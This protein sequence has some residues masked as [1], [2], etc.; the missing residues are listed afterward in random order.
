MLC[1]M[2]GRKVFLDRDSVGGTRKGGQMASNAPY[3]HPPNLACPA[4]HPVPAFRAPETFRMI[5]CGL[6][7]PSRA[8]SGVLPS[9]VTSNV[10]AIF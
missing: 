10:T 8:L 7:S 9:P 3:D 1:T 6:T 2:D 5:W 4:S